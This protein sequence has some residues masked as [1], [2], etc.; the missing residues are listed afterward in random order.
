MW[1]R[2]RTRKSRR[3]F[4]KRWCGP[5]R[6]VKALS[7]VTYRIEEKNR[8]PGKRR[9]RKVVHFNYLKPCHS[10]PEKLKPQV[11]GQSNTPELVQPQQDTV[12]TKPEVDLEWLD[13]PM[14]DLG[15]ESVP[16]SPAPQFIEDVDDEQPVPRARR[17]RRE[18]LWLR[19]FIRTVYKRTSFF[20]RGD[21]VT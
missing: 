21:S 11:E 4:I 19:D 6:V 14:V 1:Y 2:N 7:D 18:P 3:K 20:E 10:L 17:L 12:P 13:P 5:W 9:L 15:Q 16:T 8:K